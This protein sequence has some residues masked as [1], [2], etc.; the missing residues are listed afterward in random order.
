M[1]SQ[2]ALQL[3]AGAFEDAIEGFTACLMVSTDEPT[4]YRGRAMARFQIK[5]WKGAEADFRKAQDIEPSEPENALGVAMSLAMRHEIYPAI[6]EFESLLKE[7]PKFVRGQI[8]LGLLQIK[9]GAITKGKEI[10]NE[11]LNHRPSLAERRMIETALKE[12]A[13]LDKNRYY[14]P[15]FEALRKRKKE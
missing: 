3:E 2:A 8:Q 11:A 15:D 6:A 13:D 4:A 10:L 12:Q 1:I 7:N 9:V 14:R 5:D